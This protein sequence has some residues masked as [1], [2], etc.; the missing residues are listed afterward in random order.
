MTHGTG[1]LVQL[2]EL[3]TDERAR[4]APQEDLDSQG[5]LGAGL[6]CNLFWYFVKK[7]IKLPK[8]IEIEPKSNFKML[9][10]S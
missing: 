8:N 4:L 5:H 2:A 3:W 10:Y 9:I 1:G 7:Y 6:G